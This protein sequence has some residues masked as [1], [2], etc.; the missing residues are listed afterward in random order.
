MYINHICELTKS[1]F[2]FSGQIV[3]QCFF[4]LSFLWLYFT[5]M[6]LNWTPSMEWQAHFEELWRELCAGKCWI[7][8]PVFKLLQ[9]HLN[10]IAADVFFPTN[11]YWSCYF[12]NTLERKATKTILSLPFRYQL[13]S[14]GWSKF[15]GWCLPPGLY[16]VNRCEVNF[17]KICIDFSELRRLVRTNFWNIKMSSL[18]CCRTKLVR[19]F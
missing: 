4:R 13:A 11:F 15:S 8:Q 16:T 18:S 10:G 14:A 5:N 3:E 19:L 1:C 17:F 7:F 2:T 12:H 6:K 9:E